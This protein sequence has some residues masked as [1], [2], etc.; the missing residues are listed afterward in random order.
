MSINSIKKTSWL[1]FSLIVYRVI[2]F[3]FNCCCAITKDAINNRA[4]TLTLYYIGYF[5][6]FLIFLLLMKK[7]PSNNSNI[8]NKISIKYFIECLFM[9]LF[10]MFIFCFYHAVNFYKF[11]DFLTPNTYFNIYIDEDFNAFKIVLSLILPI[12]EELMFRKTIIDKYNEYGTK[13]IILLSSILFGLCH[14]NESQLEYAIFIGLVLAIVYIKT[15][16]ILYPIILHITINAFTNLPTV[17]YYNI[18]N[19]SIKNIVLSVYG[20]IHLII[21]I[22]GLILIIKKVYKTI[23]NKKGIEN[24]ILEII[25]NKNLFL[26]KYIVSYACFCFLNTF[27]PLRIY[28]IRI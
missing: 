16:N 20:I 17:F 22:L 8:V 13:S 27:F 3:A 23:K 7:V 4:I 25:D 24:F 9:C 2:G 11:K 19:E 12:F 10:F 1:G 28:G 26:N 14:E 18:Q 5:I 15:N 21:I 6:A